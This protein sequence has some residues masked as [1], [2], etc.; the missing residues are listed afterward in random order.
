MPLVRV[1]QTISYKGSNLLPAPQAVELDL[2]E[3]EIAA[4][5]VDGVLERAL[6]GDDPAELEVIEKVSWA[7]AKERLVSA[8][9]GQKGEAALADYVRG[10]IAAGL[11]DSERR[12]LL[13]GLRKSKANNKDELIALLEADAA[14]GE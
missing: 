3:G 8:G 2:S 1:L 4:L 11:G 9:G 12:S 6:P 10:S 5:V 7:S 14:D 13:A